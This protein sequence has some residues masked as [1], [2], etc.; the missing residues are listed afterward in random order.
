MQLIPVSISLSF[1][2]ERHHS[3]V[4]PHEED[5]ANRHRGC[6]C[7][8]PTPLRDHADKAITNCTPTLASGVPASMRTGGFSVGLLR[9]RSVRRMVPVSSQRSHA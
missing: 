6:P 5:E 9:T 8:K 4:R 2:T 3:P 1:R 7:R